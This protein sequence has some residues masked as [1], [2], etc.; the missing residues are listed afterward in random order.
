MFFGQYPILIEGDTE[1]TAFNYIMK[2][3]GEKYPVSL[4]PLLVRA[5]GK[6]TFIP[7]IKMLKHFKIDFSIVHDVDFPYNKN[8]DASSS[9]DANKQILNLIAE[10][11][12][13]GITV[14]HEISLPGFEMQYVHLQKEQD[15]SIKLPSSKDKPW[16]MIQAMKDQAVFDRVEELLNNLLKKVNRIVTDEPNRYF[17]DIISKW[18]ADNGINDIRVSGKKL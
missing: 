9:W 6:Y 4:R 3:R 8:G 1:Y 14:N 5:R 12:Q 7:I 18:A 15:N 10:C 2:K 11:R 17:D 13:D 16:K